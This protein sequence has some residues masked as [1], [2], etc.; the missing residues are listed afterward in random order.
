MKFYK[1]ILLLTVFTFFVSCSD[2]ENEVIEVI[3]AQSKLNVS[4]GSDARQVFDIYLPEG[5]S[6]ETKVIILLH[7]GSWVSGSK[8]DV[9]FIKD[10]IT[11]ELKDYAIVNMN[12]RLAKQGVSPFP[13]Q[14]D[15]ITSV[16]NHLKSNRSKYQI[17]NELAFV[18]VSA[19]AHLAMLWSYSLDTENQVNAVAS[20]VGPTDLSNNNSS[21]FLGQIVA[22][23]GINPTTEFFEKNSPLFQVTASVPPTI[24]FHA[25]M[26]ELVD[27]N[28][29]I[30]LRD[31]LNEL[32]VENKYTLYPLATH[33]YSSDSLLILD[34]WLQTRDF[35]LK[36]H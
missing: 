27:R 34:T 21:T 11:G 3:A 7:G 36:H 20:I 33:D 12:Y 25:G 16:V 1:L 24:Q 31:R 22:S 23:S 8:E 6:L 15:D 18:G 29:G 4:Y 30:N 13:T 26:D 5:R 28:Q 10:V 2:E 17:S 14:T 9:N 35:F 19:G 32:G